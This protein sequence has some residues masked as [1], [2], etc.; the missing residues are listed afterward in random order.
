MKEDDDEDIRGG[1]RNKKEEEEIKEGRE[2]KRRRWSNKRRGRTALT[3]MLWVFC[4]PENRDT[5]YRDIS[6]IVSFVLNHA[7]VAASHVECTIGVN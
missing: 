2:I 1:R 6:C 5:V 7:V 4:L 3:V